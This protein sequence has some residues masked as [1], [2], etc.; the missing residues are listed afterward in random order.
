MGKHWLGVSQTE[1]KPTT[2]LKVTFV[3]SF[4]EKSVKFR[5]GL[6]KPPQR[7]CDNTKND[8]HLANPVDPNVKLF[9]TDF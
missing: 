2:G 1:I 4:T 5:I 8:K 6:S 9:K 7:L 3:W